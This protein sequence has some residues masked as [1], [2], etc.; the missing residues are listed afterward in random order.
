MTLGL[1]SM[2][3]EKK[4]ARDAILGRKFDQVIKCW[5]IMFFDNVCGS[6]LLIYFKYFYEN[7]FKK[8]NKIMILNQLSKIC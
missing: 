5:K 4:K 7:K 6:L 3:D 1:H 2:N 8:I